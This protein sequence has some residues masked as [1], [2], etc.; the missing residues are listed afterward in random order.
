MENHGRVKELWTEKKRE[1]KSSPSNGAH[2][3]LF[4]FAF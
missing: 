4:S 3:A 1:E 2:T